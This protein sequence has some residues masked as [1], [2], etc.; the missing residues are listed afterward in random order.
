MSVFKVDFQ[1]RYQ[2]EYWTNKL[3]VTAPDT[4][5]VRTWVTGEI[6][7][8]L[9]GAVQ[10]S[11]TLEKARITELPFVRN[12]YTDVP[13]NL[14]GGGGATPPAPLFNVVRWQF[15]QN[16]GRQ[17]FHYFRGSIT[18]SNIG[19]DQNFTPAAKTYNDAIVNQVGDTTLPIT[20]R[21]GNPY[22][23]FTTAL[24]VGMRQLRR[25]SKRKARPI[26]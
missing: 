6:G 7:P 9:A 11:I 4:A 15:G 12:H 5:T 1:F 10:N 18:P 24:A 20:D 25:G 23:S 16:V 8:I 13:L 19:S 14:P 3:Y 21:N 22:I 17:T 2:T 26:I